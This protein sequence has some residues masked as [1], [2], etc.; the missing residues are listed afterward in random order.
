M[1]V[2]L[3]DQEHVK[4]LFALLHPCDLESRSMSCSLVKKKKKKRE[5]ERERKEYST[6]YH[7]TKFG[8]RW[9]I[10]MSKCM[11]TLKF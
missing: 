2:S 6:I 7:H 1:S 4:F 8:A 5:R 9:L 10:K 3:S 11:P